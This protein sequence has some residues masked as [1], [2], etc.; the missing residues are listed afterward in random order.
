MLITPFICVSNNIN[1]KRSNNPKY[2]INYREKLKDSNPAPQLSFFSFQ[3]DD[4]NS[5]SSQGDDDGN[6]DAGETIELRLT[7]QNTGDQDALNVGVTL[8]SANN[9]ITINNGF[10]IFVTIPLGSTGVSASN[11]VFKINS[12]CLVNYNISLE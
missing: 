3:I 12:S 11:Y 5:G 2:L 9:N 4:D 6:I 8:T 7:L 1:W 10:Q